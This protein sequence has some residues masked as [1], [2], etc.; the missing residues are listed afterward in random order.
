MKKLKLS[1]LISLLLSFTII[2]SGCSIINV[3]KYTNMYIDAFT[4]RENTQ[5]AKYS[6]VD[7]D[8][9]NDTLNTEIYSKLLARATTNK[10]EFNEEEHAT[11]T[12]AVT[13]F[14]DNEVKIVLID[15][16]E[17]DSSATVKVYISNAY[18]LFIADLKENVTT[19][20]ESEEYKPS[21]IESLTNT[22]NNA[23]IEDSVEMTITIKKDEVSKK[24]YIT[25]KSQEN[26]IAFVLGLK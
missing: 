24:Y 10:I 17:K 21:I 5:Y 22:L 9:F 18:P 1:K 15:A 14:R 26:I 25:K 8:T 19:V 4:L 16:N 2:L 6:E 11:I 7:I 23:K 3:H 13:N 12:K 20:I